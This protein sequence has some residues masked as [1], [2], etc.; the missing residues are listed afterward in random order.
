[1]IRAG[2]QGTEP[3]GDSYCLRGLGLRPQELTYENVGTT[4][5]SGVITQKLGELLFSQPARLGMTSY[6]L[7]QG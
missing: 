6:S 3:L 1:M 2:E 5:S 7:T 4:L